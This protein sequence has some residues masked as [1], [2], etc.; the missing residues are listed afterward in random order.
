MEVTSKR[1]LLPGNRYDSLIPKAKGNDKTILLSAGVDN[2]VDFIKELVP[3]TLGDT[4]S[5]VNTLVGEIPSGNRNQ[6]S[7]CKKIWEFVYQHIAYQ[8]D[9]D[10][11]EQVR[12]PSRAWRDRRSGVDC[13][14]YTVFISSCLFNLGIPHKLRIT[15]YARLDGHTPSWQHIY[16]IVPTTTGYITMDCVK[17]QFDQEEPYLEKKDYTMRLDYL[18]GLDTGD[19]SSSQS[20]HSFKVPRNVDAMDLAETNDTD[21]LGV[22]GGWYRNENDLEGLFD[23]KKRNGP[24]IVGK[25][26]R[27][28]NR[29]NPATIAL[30]NS[31]L[32]AMK[33]NF[34]KVAS[35][36]RF[37]YLSDAQAK[38]MGMDIAKLNK[39]R[40]LK[41]K[42]ESIYE[43]AG[44]KKENLRKAIL[45]G[46]GNK[47]RKVN[48]SGLSG[49]FGF[50]GVEGDADEQ[51]IL[52]AGSLSAL[53]SVQGLG[54]LGSA[55]ATS[56]AAA[57][58][59]MAPIAAA[60]SQIKGLF[61]GKPAEDASF[62]SEPTASDQNPVV[63][64][65]DIKESAVEVERE[66][67]L[68]PP[69]N[70]PPPVVSNSTNTSETMEENS[71]IT[72][73]GG[74]SPPA[75]SQPG[76]FTKLM[77]KAKENPITS[78]V[79]VGI[80]GYGT[81]KLLQPKQQASS[82]G[83]SGL[84]SKRNKKKKGKSKPKAGS[85]KKKK[86]VSVSLK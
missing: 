26:I 47:D 8:K 53:G 17:D 51:I 10:G 13:D 78:L 2:T 33:V 14:C 62:D 46:K 38:A 25:F 5:L 81:Y 42:V 73:S 30:R 32:L 3:K 65:R 23:R 82:S 70:S 61:P 71:A 63:S 36:I 31:V 24:T 68:P 48:L 50:T 6:H 27:K 69:V 21:E 67:P 15:K 59:V 45:Q 35:R 76:F 66:I 9:K 64:E 4:R 52:S 12:R 80:V 57:S 58:A 28:I 74:N 40:K 54:Q 79:I 72:P 85:K 55:V 20:G 19:E 60:L 16:V 43:K 49:L 83:L 75:S 86:Y 29:V 39:L 22:L 41:D 37:A 18:N 11:V 44:G 84:P 1:T 77:D 34:M 7:I 56:L